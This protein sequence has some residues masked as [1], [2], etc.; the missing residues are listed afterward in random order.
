MTMPPSLRPARTRVALRTVADRL[1]RVG[2]LRRAGAAEVEVQGVTDDSRVV[3]LGDLFC[4]WRGTTSDSHDYLPAAARAGAAAAVVERVVEEVELPQLVVTDGRRGAAAAASCVYGDPADQL[5][6][7]GVTGTNGKTTTAWIMRHLMATRQPTA[8]IG[9]LGLWLDAS[10]AMEGTESL[11][12]PGP[13]D[14]AALL[15]VLVERGIGGVAME[16]SS[17]ALDQGRVA[18]ARFSAAVFT[19]LTRDH[20]DY[21]GTIARYRAAKLLFVKLLRPEGVAIVNADDAAWA[22]IAEQAAH[23]LAFSTR[24][25]QKADLTALNITLHEGGSRFDL[26]TRNARV[27]VELPLLGDFNVQNAL[28][29]A[30]AALALGLSIEEIAKALAEV[31]QVPG[32]LERIAEQPCPVLRDYAHTPDALQRVLTTLRPLVKKR[33]IVVFGAG[34]D[35][36]QGK[37]PLMGDIAQRDADLAIVTSDNPRT[38]DPDAI[39]DQITA[40][41]ETGRYQRVPDRRMAIRVALETATAGD[42]ILL[43]GKGHETYQVLGTT[44]HAFDERVIVRELLERKHQGAAL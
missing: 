37:R 4:A 36:D 18:A 7:A 14:L 22:G 43:A 34:G 19:N 15:R 40:G 10:A 5:S 25:E 20:L 2:L 21:H 24:A 26:K 44:K 32:R 27:P 6:I 9:T 39:I 33:L 1:E 35:R 17:H 23:S 16:V 11:T 29:A 8:L 38:E 12:T 28:G 13:V 30:G 3:E 31:P 41:M 42:L